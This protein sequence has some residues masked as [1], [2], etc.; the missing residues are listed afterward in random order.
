MI[1]AVVNNYPVEI[2]FSGQ[3]EQLD[4]LTRRL[5]ELG[6]EPQN[7]QMYTSTKEQPRKPTAG[8]A[9]AYNEAG[10][11]CCPIHNRKLRGPNQWGKL[12]CTA[13]EGDAYCKFVWKPE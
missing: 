2:T 11:E 3:L 6:A 12:Y 5:R 13:K 1:S 8:Q 10:D 4:V 9:P 7:S